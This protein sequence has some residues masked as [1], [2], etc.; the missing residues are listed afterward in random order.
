MFESYIFEG[1][2][3]LPSRAVLHTV[4]LGA[5]A[6]CSSSSVASSRGA[7]VAA[8]EAGGSR[9]SPVITS[10]LL[11]YGVSVTDACVDWGTSVAMLDALADA[12][13]TRR[14]L[15]RQSAATAA[16]VAAAPSMDGGS[17]AAV[18]GSGEGAV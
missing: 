7:P 17:P 8:P 12:V 13:R 18:V 1:R 15:A 5:D 9:E 3:D 11:R 16:A 14:T 2:Q 6:A 10:G 4:G